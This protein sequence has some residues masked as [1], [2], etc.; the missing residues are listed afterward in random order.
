LT[1]PTISSITTHKQQFDVGLPTRLQIPSIHVDAVVSYSGL[2]SDG[3][4]DIK[5][6][7]DEVAWY[8]FGPRP[9]DI[10][11]AVIAGHYGW[12]DKKA[13]VF[14]ELHM[15]NKDDKISVVDSKGTSTTFI[16]RY[17]QKY[18]PKADASSVFESYDGKSHLN[19]ITCDGVWNNDKQTYSDRLVI[20]TDKETK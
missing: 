2:T 9:G 1:P 14:N 20:F 16:V 5:E 19:L 3:A 8:Q 17:S 13:S 4:M 7:P 11:S 12:S 6:N 10:G 18:D 15:L